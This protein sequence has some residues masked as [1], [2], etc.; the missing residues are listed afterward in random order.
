MSLVAAPALAYF[1]LHQTSDSPVDPLM[2][3]RADILWPVVLAGAL[4][5]AVHLAIMALV[6]RRRE[7][8]ETD[9]TS[10]PEPTFPVGSVRSETGLTRQVLHLTRNAERLD[11]VERDL[12]HQISLRFPVD[13]TT[14]KLLTEMRVCTNR[15]RGQISD[16]ER[17][18]RMAKETANDAVKEQV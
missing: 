6:R 2:F 8:H 4:V 14:Q 5:T 13:L 11:N 1:I 12:I 15:L 9:S 10:K 16:M 7:R 3:V 18:E 17:L